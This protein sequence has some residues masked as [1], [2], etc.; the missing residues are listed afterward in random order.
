MY[1]A[2]DQGAFLFA[3]YQTK[4]PVPMKCYWL[5]GTRTGSGTNLEGVGFPRGVLAS[6]R[7]QRSGLLTHSDQLQIRLLPVHRIWN[8][9]VV[10]LQT[11]LVPGARERRTE[12]MHE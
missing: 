9:S 6:P 4:V 3:L 11:R 7:A 10:R 8:F 2:V 1:I 5:R 12:A